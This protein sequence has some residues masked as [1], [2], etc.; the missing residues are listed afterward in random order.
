MSSNV[1]MII[2]SHLCIVGGWVVSILRRGIILW[3]AFLFSLVVSFSVTLIASKI[4]SS[5][6]YIRVIP[7]TPIV[8]RGGTWARVSIPIVWWGVILGLSTSSFRSLYRSLIGRIGLDSTGHVGEV[9]STIIGPQPRQFVHGQ[10]LPLEDVVC[11]EGGSSLVLWP[12]YIDDIFLL[13]DG[14]PESLSSFF[15]SIINS[16][17]WGISLTYKSTSTKEH[18]LD[19]E[20]EINSGQFKFQSFFF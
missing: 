7:N 10:V 1:R 16:N 2:E 17:D 19:L 13:W 11:R 12:R 15:F 4:T 6:P 18:F 8:L 3:I 5:T 20:I 14:S 9:F